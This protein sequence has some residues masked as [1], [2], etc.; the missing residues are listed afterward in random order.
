MASSNAPRDNNYVAAAL[1]E[2]DGSSPPEVMPGQIDQTTGRILTSSVSNINFADSETLG[3]AING[4][5]VT[6]T[7]ANTPNP[8]LSLELFLNGQLLTSGGVDYTLVGSTITLNTAPPSG[9]TIRAWY[10]Y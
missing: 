7:L 2:I 1:F 8:A 5:N 10:R 9:S 6:F 3:G 4:S